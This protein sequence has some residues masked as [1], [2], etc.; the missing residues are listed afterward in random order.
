[1]TDDRP[2]SPLHGKRCQENQQVQAGVAAS[3]QTWRKLLGQHRVGKNAGRA[4]ETEEQ[5]QH[6]PQPGGLQDQQQLDPQESH[7]PHRCHPCGRYATF[8]RAGGGSIARE[9]RI[10]GE[11]CS[12]FAKNRGA[13]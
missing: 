3:G 6:H 4:A 11:D 9:L 13:A 2:H 12:I 10:L 8:A 1:L 5:P 7:H